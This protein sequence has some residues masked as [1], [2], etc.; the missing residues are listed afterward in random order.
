[1]MR[2]YIDILIATIT[3]EHKEILSKTIIIHYSYL[4]SLY[5]L[6]ITLHS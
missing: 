1:M 3:M 4:S 5:I 2:K 6:E